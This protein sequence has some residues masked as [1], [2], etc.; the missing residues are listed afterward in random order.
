M[1]VFPQNIPAVLQT[2]IHPLLPCNDLVNFCQLHNIAVQAYSSLGE[3]RLAL[4]DKDSGVI[5]IPGLSEICQR[6]NRSKAQVLLRWAWQKN[7]AVIPK[8][9][10]TSRVAENVLVRD[11]CLTEM[12]KFY[13]L[14]HRK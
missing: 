14:N 1:Q 12:V 7:Y 11:F 3:G 13:C 8:T 4:P 6:N 5:Q 9:T 2:E 10:S